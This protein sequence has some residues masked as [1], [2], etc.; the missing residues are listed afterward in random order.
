MPIEQ[1]LS[2]VVISFPAK[3]VKFIEELQREILGAIR[4]E[5]PRI[6]VI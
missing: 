6:L 5:L 3:S 2:G 1:N 4:D